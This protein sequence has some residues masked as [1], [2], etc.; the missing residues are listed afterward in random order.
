MA[1]IVLIENLRKLKSLVDL[2]AFIKTADIVARV[3]ALLYYYSDVFVEKAQTKEADELLEYI[4]AHG[5]GLLPWA[6]RWVIKEETF[7][8]TIV[9]SKTTLIQVLADALA[10]NTTE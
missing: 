2:K 8:K 7:I 1:E 5:H 10:S 9:S 3:G 4:A 6:I